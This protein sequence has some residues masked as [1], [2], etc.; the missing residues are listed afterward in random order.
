MHIAFIVPYLEERY[1]GPVTVARDAGRALSRLGHR[2][3]CWATAV[4]S[5]GKCSSWPHEV[6]LFDV[7]WPSRW[8]RSKEFARGLSWEADSIDI[9]HI[10]EFWPF[11]VLAASRIGRTHGVPYVLRPAG[12]LDPWC[13]RNGPW[14]RIKKHLYLEMFGRRMI[15]QAA[16]LHATSEREANAFREL[17]PRSPVSI[18][19]NG[20]DIDAFAQ[21]DPLE[22]ETC[23]PCL[24]DRPVVLFLSRLSPKKGLDLLI[25]AWAD[26][27]SCGGHKDAILVIAGPDFAGYG[28]KVQAAIEHHGLSPQVHMIGLV[29]GSSKAALLRRADIFV[30]PSYSENFGI[31]VVEA[32]A[33]GTPVITTT[34]TPWSQLEEVG[35]GRCIPTRSAELAHAIRELLRMSTSQRRTM[36]RKG[37]ELVRANYT[38]DR[39]VGKYLMLYDSILNGRS[40][41]LYPQLSVIP[42]GH[43]A[44]SFLECG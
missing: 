13:L 38:W 20:V 6:H 7:S 24:K 31:V 33:S 4:S 43:G 28:K 30:L 15:R 29:T 35:A 39:I 44:T 8:R 17:D 10:S 21:G 41:P 3:S 5:D 32:L 25:S 11:P 18:I 14:K 19:P 40:A 27:V 1:G 23:W 26:V 2:V 34:G 22:A 42:P 36:G 9:M 37:V 12:S 16:C